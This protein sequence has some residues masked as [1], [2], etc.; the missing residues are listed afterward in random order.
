[1][2]QAERDIQRSIASAALGRV[3]QIWNE[4]NNQ[5]SD[6]ARAHLI[7]EGLSAGA[8]CLDTLG[9]FSVLSV[10]SSDAELERT[11]VKL[12]RVDEFGLLGVGATK[13]MRYY[14]SPKGEIV[15]MESRQ[16][17]LLW[18]ERQLT[19]S[20]NALRSVGIPTLKT[21]AETLQRSVKVSGWL[22][23]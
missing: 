7:D 21:I 12:L 22:E 6:S 1:M 8:S 14:L 3:N 13:D 19:L 23:K 5:Q 10:S 11:G 2:Q 20:Y 18:D 9:F 16:G 17:K 15:K 4:L